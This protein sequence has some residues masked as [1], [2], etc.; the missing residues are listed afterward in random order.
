M[1]KLASK[2]LVDI[3]MA[4]TMMVSLATG[5]LIWVALPHGRQAG[6]SIFLGITRLS[7]IDIHTYSSMA[8]AVVLLVHVVLNLRLFLTMAKSVFTGRKTGRSA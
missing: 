4:V 8:F 7:W 2:V 6:Q 5:L 3:G 1:S